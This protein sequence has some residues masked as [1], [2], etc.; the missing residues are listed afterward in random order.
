MKEDAIIIGDL[1][2]VFERIQEIRCPLQNKLIKLPCKAR[3]P[4]IKFLPRQ[5]RPI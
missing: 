1:L 2:K 4:T 3:L 5:D